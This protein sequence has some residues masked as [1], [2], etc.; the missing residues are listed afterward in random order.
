MVVTSFVIFSSFA[1][2]AEAHDR[3]EDGEAAPHEGA[4]VHCGFW[5]LKEPVCCALPEGGAEEHAREVAEPGEKGAPSFEVVSS[6]VSFFSFAVGVG[7]SFVVVSF[8]VRRSLVSEAWK[9]KESK[10]SG[11][12]PPTSRGSCRAWFPDFCNLRASL[13]SG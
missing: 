3:E 12:E 4:L 2:G 7:A 6:F 10:D 11:A 5:E 9:G 8:F 1:V 13:C